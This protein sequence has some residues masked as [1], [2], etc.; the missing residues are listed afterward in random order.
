MAV[1]RNMAISASLLLAWGAV[2]LIACG[3]SGQ[4]GTPPECQPG[5]PSEACIVDCTNSAACSERTI[6]CPA[7]LTCKIDC[8]G[9]DS[10][11]TSNII[12]PPN[13]T[14][15]LSCEG[16]DACGDMI[17][18]CGTGNCELTCGQTATA[19]KGAKMICGNGECQATCSGS[20]P[21]TMMGC[22][23]AAVCIECK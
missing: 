20:T 18:Q 6:T 2:F 3:N 11:D 19:C 1:H 8:N 9:P 10:C 15:Q 23:E 22:Q 4:P 13:A 12:C 14:C 16:I 5:G 21:P 7:G 17:L